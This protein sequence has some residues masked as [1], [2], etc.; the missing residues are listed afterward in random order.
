[1]ASLVLSVWYEF[2]E[3]RFACNFLWARYQRT[4][5]LANLPLIPWMPPD[6]PVYSFVTSPRGIP[7][8]TVRPIIRGAGMPSSFFRCVS[9]RLNGAVCFV[10]SGELDLSNV[11]AFR[12]D[13]DKAL[14]GT[15]DIILQLQELTYL[16]STG[17]NLL[18][19]VHRSLSCTNRRIV[20]VGPTPQV[21]R[22]LGVLCLAQLMPIVE[23]V[24]EALLHLA[25]QHPDQTSSAAE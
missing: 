11:A 17:I 5:Q 25:T 20:L 22:I 8:P 6:R 18:L 12:A 13:V 10:L 1:M 24:E 19:D 23:T 15:G 4:R 16:D 3:Q 9:Q 14:G 21:R 7:H 2:Q